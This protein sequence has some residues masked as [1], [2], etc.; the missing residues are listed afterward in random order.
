MSQV[1][2]TSP[3]LPYHTNCLYVPNAAA[4]ETVS[5][6]VNVLLKLAFLNA[7]VKE[8]LT[9]IPK[10]DEHIFATAKSY[11]TRA[12][13]FVCIFSSIVKHLQYTFQCY[14]TFLFF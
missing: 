2:F 11:M 3:A 8:M 1:M 5:L 10:L 6:P 14:N 4:E 13:V 9:C 7:G 12:Y